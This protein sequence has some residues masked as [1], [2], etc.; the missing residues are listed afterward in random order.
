MYDVIVFEF[1]EE[2][3]IGEWLFDFLFDEMVYWL[4]FEVGFVVVFGELFVCG[5]F[6]FD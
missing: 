4:G 6:E 1:V 3:C 5:V 2:D